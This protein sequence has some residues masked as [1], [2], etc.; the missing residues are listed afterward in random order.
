MIRTDGKNPG[1]LLYNSKYLK[2]GYGQTLQA[3]IREQ[4][5]AKGR[6]ASRIEAEKLFPG[7]L[8]KQQKYINFIHDHSGH[9]GGKNPSDFWPITVRPFKGAH[10]ACFPETLCVMPI[11]ATCPQ[12]ICRK[13]GK[14]RTRITEGTSPGAFNI[15]V[16]DVK[17]KR[18]KHF[19]RVASSLEV[20][21]YKE[22]VTH[23]GSGIRTIG[24]SD[25]G[26]GQGWSAGVVMDIFA[27]SGTTCLVAKK[28]GR[29]Y[30]GIEL[31]Q[32]YVDMA[33]KRL[34]ALPER[35]D[36]FSKGG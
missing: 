16:R 8:A 2:H 28:L 10:F 25:C 34:E 13:C 15:R 30:V 14:P 33:K 5:V 35:L 29:S 4:S 9:P 26:C 6:V 31:K 7:N 24:W 12:W 20:Q 3:T 23:A 21:N 27:G 22:G 17:E 36:T 1:D 18:I 19:D 32:E 11:K